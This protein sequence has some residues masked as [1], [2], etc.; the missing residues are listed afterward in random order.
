MRSTSPGAASTTPSSPIRCSADRQQRVVRARLP[1]RSTIFGTQASLC[2]TL[3]RWYSL[4]LR[5][6]LQRRHAQG[7]VIAVAP[8]AVHLLDLVH[9]GLQRLLQN[10]NCSI[11]SMP[12]RNARPARRPSP[13]RRSACWPASPARRD[14]Y[15]AECGSGCTVISTMVTIRPTN[16]GSNICKLGH[17]H[18]A[19]L[20]GIGLH[21]GVQRSHGLRRQFAVELRAICPQRSLPHRMASAGDPISSGV[22]SNT[23][24]ARRRRHHAGR[25]W[26][27]GRLQQVERTQQVR[28]CRHLTPSTAAAPV[29]PPL[30]RGIGVQRA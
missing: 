16:H 1:S 14:G 30:P 18:R 2:S 24:S 6:H 5:A 9:A 22:I 29:A 3:M 20:R 13:A 27:V 26:I 12:S 8:C 19:Q 28:N 4:E 25:Q 23:T 21:P 17:A 10:R 11:L 15:Q 7:G